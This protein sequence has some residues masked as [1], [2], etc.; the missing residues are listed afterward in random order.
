MYRSLRNQVV[1]RSRADEK[2]WERKNLDDK[3]S[4]PTILWRWV[5]G[6]LGWGGGGTPTQLFSEGKMVTSPSG[7]AG[8]MNNFFLDKIRNLR[9]LIPLV[10]T[11][12]LAKMKEAMVGRKCK[13]LLQT[14]MVEDVIKIIKSLKNSSATGVDY[15]D[16]RT[17]KIAAE[18]IAPALTHII[19]LSIQTSTFPNIWKYAKVVPLLKSFIAD[20][21]LPKSYRPVALLPILSKVLEKNDPTV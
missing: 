8:T 3:E 9:S 6:R 1:S 2:E 18:I 16:T 10:I 11:D 5:K 13:F 20:P 15:I 7:L 19:N 4:S 14:V 12:P 17:V 21:V